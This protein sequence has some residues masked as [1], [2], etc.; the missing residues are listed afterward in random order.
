MLRYDV[1]VVGGGVMGCAT[2]YHLAKRGRRVLLLEQFALGHDRGS[3]HGHSRIIRLAYDGPDYV[4]LAQAAYPL[5][6]V[7]EQD[8]G[9]A[10]MLQ[11]GGLDF[12]PPGTR[13]FEATRATLAA[14]GIEHELLDAAAIVERFPQFELPADTIGLYQHDAGILNASACV[15]AL[16]AEARRHGAELRDQE[17]ARQIGAAGAGVEVRTDLGAYQA[18][19]LVVSAG[20]WARPLLHQLGLDLPLTV[21]REQ[22]AFFVPRHPEQFA[23][24]QFPIFIHHDDEHPSAYGF[25]VFGLPG[26]KVAYHQGGPAIA[27]ESD[28]RAADPAVSQSLRDYLARWVPAA[29]GELLL[30]QTCRYTTTP[31]EHFIIDR[32]PERPQI[33]IGSPCSG[34]GFKF[35]VLIGAILADLAERGATEHPIG[36]FGLGRF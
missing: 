24:G 19:R 13:S 9:A 17:P 25:P 14:L 33:V 18:D 2:A 29:A 27:P 3:S 32:H 23:P 21:T 10:L 1:I 5:W 16:A 15:A 26:V 35:G 11:T 20:S 4:R 6:R 31:D 36:K 8:S 30:A 22:V 12:A 34:H 28:E 7:L